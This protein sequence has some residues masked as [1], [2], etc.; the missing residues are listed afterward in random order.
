[1]PRAR[2]P[3]VRSSIRTC[4][5]SR[6]IL[7][8]SSSSYASGALREPG[9]RTT[10][11]TPPA[12]SSATT[13]W[14]Q[15]P[16]SPTVR[17]RRSPGPS[18]GLHE[19]SLPEHRDV[20]VGGAADATAP[21]AP[22]SGRRRDNRPSRPGALDQVVGRA[23]ATVSSP[24]A[25]GSSGSA[26]ASAT[27]ARRPIEVSSALDTT[28]GSPIRSA[29]SRQARTPPSGW[30]LS[31]AMSAAPARATRYGS[32]E[33]RIDSSAATGTSRCARASRRRSSASSSMLAHGCS[34]YSRRS[35]SVRASARH[36]SSTSQ[37]PFASTRIRP[38]EPRAPRTA[39]TRARSSVSD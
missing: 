29:I 26:A 25:Y 5:R 18:L 36:A 34:A 2:N 3:A 9:D 8:A 37:A 23:A 11:R 15:R 4:S 6:P 21:G 33:R 14:A 28:T 30:T 22:R 10:S 32:S 16:A 1:M 39:S 31:T 20:G 27:P 19:P 38:P 35:G 17:A 12:S 24:H 7:S 13:T